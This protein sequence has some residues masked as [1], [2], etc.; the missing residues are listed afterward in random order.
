MKKTIIIFFLTF[1]TFC[2]V[3]SSEITDDYMDIAKNYFNAENNQKAQE[4]INL[5]LLLEPDNQK[6]KSFNVIMIPEKTNIN[7]DKIVNVEETALKLSANNQVAILNNNGVDCY[8]QKDFNNAVKLFRKAINCDKKNCVPYYNLALCYRAKG[9]KLLAEYYFKKSYSFNKNFTYG[10]V[11]LANMKTGS[12]KLNLLDMAA[13]YK[14]PFA[15]YY[16]AEDCFEKKNYRKALINYSEALIIEPNIA[17]AYLRAAQC[18]L[19]LEDYDMAIINLQKYMSYISD[20]DDAYYLLSK[21][22]RSAGYETK[23]FQELK[24][25]ISLQRKNEYLFELAKMYYADQNYDLSVYVIKNLIKDKPEA[26]YYNLLGLNFYEKNDI[27]NAK[28]NFEKALEMDSN[29]AMIYFNMSK[30]DKEN[31]SLYIE[32][33][34]RIVPQTPQQAI[35]LAKMYYKISDNESA[36]KTIDDAILK[37]G[38]DKK[39]YKTKMKLCKLIRN[40]NEYEK[41]KMEL[42]IK[43]G[44]K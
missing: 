13:K 29:N 8:N 24:R 4:Y 39:L 2:P 15:Y 25:A 21:A 43:F 6:A 27:Q 14:N 41:T 42:S 37:Y 30:C 38:D 16:L 1:L 26:N 3:F 19:E 5:I 35:N 17:Q 44:V 31:S 7:K 23:S 20:N 34:K 32:K 40:Y 36:L 22:Y 12:A 10:I 18:C 33:A 11:S 28:Y 9:N